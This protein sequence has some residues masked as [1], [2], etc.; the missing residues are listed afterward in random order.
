MGKSVCLCWVH[1]YILV[2]LTF[3]T[4]NFL[5]RNVMF[6]FFC[7]ACDR[8]CVSM[9]AQKPMRISV[10]MYEY[11]YAYMNVCMMLAYERAG[12]HALICLSVCT[13]VCMYVCMYICLYVYF[14]ICM[15]VRASVCMYIRMSNTFFLPLT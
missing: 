6:V 2:S 11:V 10:C 3:L 14:Y 13:Y 9:R 4:S 1:D 12:V 5:L 15:H 8:A 7:S